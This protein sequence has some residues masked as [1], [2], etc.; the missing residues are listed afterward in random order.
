MIARI[1][2]LEAD[3]L[4]LWSLPYVAAGWL[5]V[6]GRLALAAPLRTFATLPPGGQVAICAAGA[7]LL[8]AG[9]A[10]V[11]REPVHQRS[12]V[13]PRWIGA[14]AAGWALAGAGW[15]AAWWLLGGAAGH[16][17]PAVA[18]GVILLAAAIGGLATGLGQWRAIRR[19]VVRSER[20]LVVTLGSWIAGGVLAAVIAG[21]P[22]VATLQRLDSGLRAAPEPADRLGRDDLRHDRRAG[23]RPADRPGLLRAARAHACLV[24]L[25]PRPRRPPAPAR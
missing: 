12:A 4:L 9:V 15:W 6:L 11:Q 14:S 5:I 7:G 16:A 18:P 24:P 20:W 23:D 2:R 21:P 22:L 3:F 13:A 10:L 17:D 25:T 19:A 1:P 8:G